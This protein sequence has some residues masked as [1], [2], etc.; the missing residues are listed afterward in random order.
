MFKRRTVMFAW[1]AGRGGGGHVCAPSFSFAR[2]LIVVKIRLRAAAPVCQAFAGLFA[3]LA[4]AFIFEV[5]VYLS[6]GITN[7]ATRFQGMGQPT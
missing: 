5:Y 7:G 1:T 4:A 3:V 6:G 2:R